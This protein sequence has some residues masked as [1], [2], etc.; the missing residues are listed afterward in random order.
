[1]QMNRDT[2]RIAYRQ[3]RTI[4]A[5]EEAVNRAFS[6]GEIPGFMHLYSGQEA[7]AVRVCMH[8]D[9]RDYIGSTHRGHGHCIAKGCEIEGMMMEIFGKAGACYPT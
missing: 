2:L 1:M 6:S 8:L 4:R 7:C 9:D 5:F 3:M